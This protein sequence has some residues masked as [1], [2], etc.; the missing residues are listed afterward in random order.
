MENTNTSSKTQAQLIARLGIE[1]VT[2]EWDTYRN[3]TLQLGIRTG[4]KS[5]FEC[6]RMSGHNDGTMCASYC[7]AFQSWKYLLSERET[8]GF[9]VRIV[10]QLHVL[11]CEIVRP[12]SLSAH[13][14][15]VKNPEFHRFPQKFHNHLSERIQTKPNGMLPFTKRFGE[16]RAVN[17]P[18]SFSLNSFSTKHRLFRN[19]FHKII[20]AMRSFASREQNFGDFIW[21]YRRMIVKF[22]ELFFQQNCTYHFSRRSRRK[23]LGFD[24]REGA[25]KM[26][27]HK[28]GWCCPTINGR[29]IMDD[30]CVQWRSCMVKRGLGNYIDWKTA[31]STLKK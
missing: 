2:A 13:F 20:C 19:K 15:A 22:F 30:E 23:E 1:T 4:R 11:V 5:I 10:K 16:P 24:M 28:Y 17:I 29:L 18:H 8:N 21:F 6:G 3:A 12:S 14:P 27:C 31:P 7:G 9:E 25:R 26:S